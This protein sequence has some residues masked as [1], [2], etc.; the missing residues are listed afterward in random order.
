MLSSPLGLV[1]ARLHGQFLPTFMLCN[2]IGLVV[3][4]CH[5]RHNIVLLG[6]LLQTFT[7]ALFVNPLTVFTNV[8]QFIRC[9]TRAIWTVILSSSLSAVD[10]HY[11][12][13]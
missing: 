12:D 2:T 1:V 3:I 13:S 11:H 6:R 9:S 5:D 8:Q 4:R 7:T 10:S